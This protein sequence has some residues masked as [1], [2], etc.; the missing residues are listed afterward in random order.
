MDAT[1]YIERLK[2]EIPDEKNSQD[3]HPWTT[4]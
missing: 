3:I 1:L 4:K 2:K